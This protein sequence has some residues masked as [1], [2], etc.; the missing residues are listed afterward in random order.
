MIPVL[1]SSTETAFLTNGL[2]RLADSVKCHV[3]EERNGAYELEMTYPVGG[4]HYSD[5]LISNIIYAKPS[6][7][8]APQPFRIYSITKPINGIVTVKAEH[9]S[10]QLSNIPVMP[11][12]AESVGNALLGLKSHAAESCPF[13]FFT[14]K[15]TSAAFYTDVPHS[16]RSLIGGEAGSILDIYGGELEW[17]KWTVKLWNERGHDSGV[18]L[19]YGKNLTDVEQE[20]N[21]DGVYTGICPYWTGTDGNSNEVVVLLPEGVLH[22]D[23][24]GQYPYPRTIPIDFTSYFDEQPT[25]AQLRAAGQQYIVDNNIGYPKV[26]IKVSFVPLWQTEEY[27]NVAPL[28][29]VNLCDTVT[30]Y[31]EKLGIDSKAKVIKTDY[32]VLTERYISIEVGDAVTNLAT[33]FKNVANAAKQEFSEATL[34]FS[35]E[36]ERATAIIAGVYGGHVVFD[37]TAD[38]NIYQILIMD[39]AT[40]EEAVNVIRLNQAGIGFSQNGYN[41]PFNSAW[42]IDG[43]LD[44]GVINVLN[45]S[46]NLITTGIIRDRTGRNYWNLETG[47]IS[48]Q[49]TVA[50]IGVGGRNYIRQSNTLTFDDYYFAFAFNFNNDEAMLNTNLMEVAVN[51]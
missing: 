25:E 17:D 19:R 33:G 43:T 13:D 32:D 22:A 44:M 31:F 2:G 27:K 10:Y 6:D 18:M 16:M 9:V 40:K 23:T 48:I 26:S 24:A 50:D 37:R 46:A 28:E 47:E 51:G 30:V 29:R 1:F 5:I 38:G 20:E 7:G 21:I 4:R 42:L 41:G 36:I 14:D 15:T 3:V 35:K 8:K 34:A 49:A 39:A 45:M 12:E 11:F